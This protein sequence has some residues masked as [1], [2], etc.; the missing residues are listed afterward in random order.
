LTEHPNLGGAAIGT[1]TPDGAILVQS[2]GQTIT[3]DGIPFEEEPDSPEIERA[4]QATFTHRF[5]MSWLEAITRIGFIGRGSFLTDTN[6]FIYFVLSVSIQRQT[7]GWAIMRVVT[8]S[9]SFDTPPDDFSIVPVELGV[10]I[11]K[12]PRYFYAFLGD[13]YGSITE[14]QNQMVI[15]LLQ[16]YFDNANAQF[17]DAIVELLKASMNSDAGEGEQKPEYDDGFDENAKVSG[18]NLA[19]RAAL[20]IITKYWRGT[21]TPYL[22]GYQ[23][24]WTQYYFRPTV[25]NPGGYIEDPFYE[26]SPQ[27]PDYFF[28]TE[29]PPNP[30]LT[31]L[32]EITWFNPQAYSQDGIRGGPL[33]ISWLR[34]ADQI[35]YQRTWFK[36]ERTWI[37]SPVGFWDDQLYTQENRPTAPQDYLLTA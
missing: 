15:R 27:V 13:G 7:G 24:T 11:I 28:S 17:R 21:E 16:D 20:E 36:V 37:G 19:K 9:K 4:E 25:L 14:Q 2:G 29:F 12:H 22:I 33:N 34:K 6:G 8:E 3:I 32:D 10:H 30:G 1:P 23:V 5:R 31:I 26:A 35:E 18:T